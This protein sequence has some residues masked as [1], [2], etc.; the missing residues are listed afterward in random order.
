MAAQLHGT[1][2]MIVLRTLLRGPA[3]GH[4]ITKLIQQ[5]S[6]DVLRVDHGS[7]YLALQ[8]L[9]EQSW[10]D[11]KWGISDNNRRARFYKLTP[12]GRR[13][14]TDKAAEWSRIAAAMA[15][16]LNPDESEA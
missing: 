12:S 5:T 7:L 1:L 10:V 4:G 16:I 14:L 6:E 9:E 11:A 3:H 15:R 8:R 2:D 13:R